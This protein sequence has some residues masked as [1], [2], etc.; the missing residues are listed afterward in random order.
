MC[1]QEIFWSIY[2]GKSFALLQIDR[3]TVEVGKGGVD[4]LHDDD[5]VEPESKWFLCES[6]I[7]GIKFHYILQLFSTQYKKL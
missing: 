3:G 5:V 7:D 1:M 4:H 2:S 6:M